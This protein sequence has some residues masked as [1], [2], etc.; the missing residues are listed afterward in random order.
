MYVYIIE[1]T[2]ILFSEIAEH[3]GLSLL[4]NTPRQT[5]RIE[6]F[7]QK[8]PL[9]QVTAS[10]QRCQAAPTLTLPALP[11][12]DKPSLCSLGSNQAGTIS[13]LLSREPP[14]PKGRT[15]VPGGKAAEP[16]EDPVSDSISCCDFTLVGGKASSC[17]LMV[18]GC[19]SAVSTLR[20]G[21]SLAPACL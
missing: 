16:E 7:S 3:F 9:P 1:K 17:C 19:A 8:F 11:D 5:P 20:S 10:L 13:Y 6:H 12:A 15:L 14:S 18:M 2:T 21:W 4:E